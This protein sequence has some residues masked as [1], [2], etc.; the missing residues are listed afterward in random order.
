MWGLNSVILHFNVI[1]TTS[2]VVCV[3]LIYVSVYRSHTEEMGEQ[4]NKIRVHFLYLREKRNN[5]NVPHNW[6]I[7]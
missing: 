6:G 7:H 3:D 1:H 2:V 4:S 5:L